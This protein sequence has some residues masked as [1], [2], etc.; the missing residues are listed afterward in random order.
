M[1][2]LHTRAAHIFGW[3]GTP[4]TPS[5]SSGGSFERKLDPQHSQQGQS[6]QGQ[7]GEDAVD[8]LWE[9][10]WCP[11]LQGIARLCCDSRKQVRASAVT[12][13]QRSL[14]V[15]DLQA[16]SPAEWEA[17]FHK[18]LFPLLAKLLEPS[19][20]AGM[21]E[22]RMRAAT[23]LCKVFLQ[24]LTP[25][26]SL[27]T[28]TALWLTILDFMDKYL[29][30][31]RADLLHE[32][33][34]ESMK[35]MLLVM[36]TAGIFHSAE[37][38]SELWAITWD[39]ID[40]F[41]PSLREQVFSN[42]PPSEINK[43]SHASAAPGPAQESS[44]PAPPAAVP[45]GTAAGSA[46]TGGAPASVTTGA[47]GGASASTG[48]LAGAAAG[49][50][51]VTGVG[52]TVGTAETTVASMREIRPASPLHHEELMTSA[53]S[54]ILG[55]PLPSP[56]PA[57]SAPSPFAPPSAPAPVS[58]VSLTSHPPTAG[59]VFLQP[60]PP[61]GSGHSLVGGITKTGAIPG[62][63]LAAPVPASNPTPA[64]TPAQALA[65]ANQSPGSNPVQASALSQGG[66]A[67]S[68]GSGSTHKAHRCRRQR[69]RTPVTSRSR[70]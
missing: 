28:F 38:Y 1:H 50:A 68:P 52:G 49:A 54:I 47:G 30:A 40:T 62:V 2:T 42:H 58:L 26:L 8:S 19:T 65:G 56:S 37:G 6:E 66:P 12:Y 41:L 44:R 67:S 43:S 4:T 64:P 13:L 53:P 63:A 18:V 45:T 29:Q 51:G 7:D 34:P 33:I 17:C 39:R 27:P 24:H 22:T 20:A 31:D 70:V 59:P 5:G 57:L 61:T 60:L 48:G 55:P 3:F 69:R 16:L 46:S 25:L 21:E 36:E 14:L 9:A 15:H 10:G 23:L 11:L 32:A 35:N